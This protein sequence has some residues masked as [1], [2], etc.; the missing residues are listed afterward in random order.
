MA[1]ITH[2]TSRRWTVIAS[3]LLVGVLALIVT[4]TGQRA[5]FSPVAIMVVAAIGLAAAMLQL[6]LRDPQNQT[7]RH[8]VAMGLNIVGIIC[9]VLALFADALQLSPRIGKLMALAAVGSFAVSGA[10]LLHRFRQSNTKQ[11]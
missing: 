11:K 6:R 2:G 9:A 10:T 5:F 7:T 1:P 8:P 4:F 3:G